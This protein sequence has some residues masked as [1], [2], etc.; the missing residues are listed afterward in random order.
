[1]RRKRIGVAD[2]HSG[3]WPQR[4][5]GRLTE[6]LRVTLVSF[7]Q[8]NNLLGDSVAGRVDDPVGAL[9]S[10]KGHFESDAHETDGFR[11][12]PKAVQVCS[13]R[14]DSA[15]AKSNPGKTLAKTERP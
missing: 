11:V 13:D 10:H 4:L 12:E 8:I 15:Q 6:T 14:H 7:R 2:Y 5:Q 3:A 1:V 9:E